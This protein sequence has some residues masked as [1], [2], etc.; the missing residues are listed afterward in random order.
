M[1]KVRVATISNRQSLGDKKY[2][3]L[4]RDSSSAY[5]VTSS[6]PKLIM[7]RNQLISP[8]RRQDL[9]SHNNRARA[10]EADTPTNSAKDP[11]LIEFP[12]DE[13]SVLVIEQ[14]CLKH[15]STPLP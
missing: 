9:S 13:E 10:E 14:V 7:I 15:I 12:A 1:E 4:T 11:R 2:P 8:L 6:D 5:H 3:Y